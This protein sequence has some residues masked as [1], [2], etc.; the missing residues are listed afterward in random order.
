MKRKYIRWIA[1]GVV[2]AGLVSLVVWAYSYTPTLTARASEEWSRGRVIGHAPIGRPIDLQI[3]PGGDALVVWPGVEGDLELAHIGPEGEVRSRALSLGSGQPRDPQFQVA[4]GGRLHLVSRVEQEPHHIVRY[5]LLESD[6]ALVGEPQILSDADRDVALDVPRM[7]PDGQGGVH[8]LWADEDGI[9][10][11]RISAEG[12]LLGEPVLVLAQGLTPAVQVDDAGQIHM[13][14]RQQ[15]RANTQAIY[16][17][18]LDPDR[19][20]IGDPEEVTQ[21]FLRT[22]QSIGT[23]ALGLDEEAA[24][25]LWTI[26]DMREVSYQGQYASFPLG[27]PE[28]MQVTDLPLRQGWNPNGVCPI[29]GKQSPLVVALSEWIIGS[30]G[31][32]QVQVA[33]T[34]LAH[35]GAPAFGVEQIVSGSDRVSMEPVPARD[36]SAD[37]HMAWLEPVRSK[38]FQVV[39]ASTAPGVR[40]NY[41]AVT[42]WDVVD[43]VLSGTVEFLT[44]AV[45]TLVPMLFLWTVLPM[46]GLIVYHIFSG[47]ERLDIPSARIALVL[48]ILLE[49][50]LT[51]IFPPRAAAGSGFGLDVS[52]EPLR[53]V[54]PIVTSVLG[55]LI[56][57]VV[58]RREEESPL[59]LAFFAFTGVHGFLQMLLYYIL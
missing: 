5:A 27:H 48:A 19:S 10:W 50:A 16:Y 36:S 37:L 42:L 35:Q 53:W 38:R 23:L 56:A 9:Q 55:A 3:G 58:A 33:L 54:A 29:E 7:V 43:T 15:L 20:E 45:L 25:V 41:N 12:M 34:A 59:F 22:G 14:W 44:V 30:D 26:R 32:Q 24:Y 28:Q 57:L 51:A 17:A 49:I 39:Y 11:A 8:V 46:M 31:E 13:T 6:G 18:V 1:I 52:W 47:E 4:P 21:I 2:L 40:R